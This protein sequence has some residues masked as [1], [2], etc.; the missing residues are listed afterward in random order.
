MECGFMQSFCR[1]SSKFIFL[2]RFY[3]YKSLESVAKD[4]V[5]QKGLIE[6]AVFLWLEQKFLD[7][8][9]TRH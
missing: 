9:L 6:M 3:R 2:D 1:P 4:D 7:W 8:F 5:M